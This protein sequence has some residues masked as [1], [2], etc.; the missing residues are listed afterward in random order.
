MINRTAVEG[1]LGREYGGEGSKGFERLWEGEE[2]KILNFTVGGFRFWLSFDVR[3]A[4]SGET[5]SCWCH[6]LSR[7]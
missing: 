5:N 6:D 1:C 4:G 2:R 7:L 3:T